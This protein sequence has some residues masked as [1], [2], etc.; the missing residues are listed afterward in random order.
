[1]F[2]GTLAPYR[3]FPS[4]CFSSPLSAYDNVPVTRISDLLFF[5]IAQ[6]F[7]AST[8]VL[9]YAAVRRRVV[10]SCS[11]LGLAAF[12]F[13][14]AL[15]NCFAETGKML[16]NNSS[17]ES[18]EAGARA[19]TLLY[20]HLNPDKQLSLSG[21]SVVQDTFKNMGA[22]QSPGKAWSNAAESNSGLKK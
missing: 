5:T 3:G 13:F 7:G 1:M 21:G 12:L 14:G 15:G 8:N 4:G 6:Y 2:G 17:I 10:N 18:G 9:A 16:G 20:N 22:G 19:G 11:V